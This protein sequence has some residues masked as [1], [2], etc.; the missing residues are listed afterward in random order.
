MLV[1]LVTPA[2]AI[3]TSTSQSPS[4]PIQSATGKVQTSTPTRCCE[5]SFCPISGSKGCDRSDRTYGTYRNPC[6]RRLFRVRSSCKHF[7][8]N[9]GFGAD[10]AEVPTKLLWERPLLP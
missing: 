2:R 1:T 8:E 9:E 4:S 6:R 5:S 3:I 10:R 7:F